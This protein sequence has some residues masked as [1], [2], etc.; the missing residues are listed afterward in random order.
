MSDGHPSD[1]LH[2][3]N[4]HW[5]PEIKPYKDFEDTECDENTQWVQMIE[6]DVPHDKWDQC[7]Q[8]AKGPGK[9]HLIILVTPQSHDHSTVLRK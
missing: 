8:I 5:G 2:G 7:A 9:L 1:R 4:G 3:L 6:G